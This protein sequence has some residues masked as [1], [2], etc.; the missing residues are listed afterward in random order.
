MPKNRLLI[1]LVFMFASLCVLA[2]DGDESNELK[3]FAVIATNR[4]RIDLLEKAEQ[5][6]IISYNINW[7]SKIDLEK[8]VV[9]N[10][11][12]RKNGDWAKADG[13]PL[14]DVVY[15]FGVYKS[16][17]DRKEKANVLREHLR[18]KKIPFINPEHAMKAVNNKV[19]F[20]KLMRKNDI[21]HPKT[22]SFSKRNLNKMLSQYDVLFIK[23]TLGSKG[24]GIIIVHK[25]IGTHPSRYVIEYK[26][27]S[28]GNWVLVQTE[29]HRKKDVYDAVSRARRHLKKS[30]LPYLI[31]EG[32]DFFRFDNE[33]TDFRVN[34]QRGTDGKLMATGI[35]MRVGGNLSQNGRPATV[36]SV[37]AK[38]GLDVEVVKA[39]ALNIAL[40]THRAL[41]RSAGKKVKI[42]DLGMDLVVDKHGKIYVIEANHK[43]GYVYQYLL[44]HPERDKLFGLPSALEVCKAKDSMHE[45]QLLEYGRYLTATRKD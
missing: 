21:A 20:A 12:I 37:L 31:Q 14:P 3:V 7:N 1:P 30:N 18:S 13:V 22:Y 8:N 29:S 26:K 28:G 19:I 43:N 11:W 27:W 39:E 32:I 35:V 42:G 9:N 24:R 40:R 6:G 45:D 10:V 44:K 36:E 33:Q 5:Q 2:F 25:I 23:P 15:D 16:A 34:T 4:S 38:S 41:E 17:K